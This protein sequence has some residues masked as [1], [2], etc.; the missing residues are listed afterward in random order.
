MKLG[1]IRKVTVSICA[2]DYKGNTEKYEQEA[3]INQYF[4]MRTKQKAQKDLTEIYIAFIKTLKEAQ[5]TNG[6]YSYDMKNQDIANFILNYLDDDL[7]FLSDW[8][9]EG[10]DIDASKY[11]VDLEAV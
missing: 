10:D 11:R 3:N 7:N 5:F 9:E 4:F 6:E 8:N 1:D 2:T